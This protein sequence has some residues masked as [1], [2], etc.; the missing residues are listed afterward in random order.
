MKRDNEYILDIILILLA[1]LTLILSNILWLDIKTA[2]IPSQDEIVETE[3]DSTKLFK[4][5]LKPR[6]VIATYNGN[7]HFVLEFDE[8]YQ[9]YQKDIYA[10]FSNLNPNDGTEISMEEYLSLQNAPSLV[11]FYPQ[12][13]DLST[14]ISLIDKPDNAEAPISITEIYF[15]RDFIV[16]GNSQKHFKFSKKMNIDDTLSSLASENLPTAQNFKEL[17]NVN[18]NLYMPT[19]NTYKFKKIF[20]SND[21]QTL[22]ND[23]SY[24]DNLASRFL[25]ANVDHIKDIVQE[26]SRNLIYNNEYLNLYYSG[27]I[28]YENFDKINSKTRNLYTSFKSALSFIS[29]KVGNLDL[30]LSEITPIGDEESQGYSFKFNISEDSLPV[31]VNNPNYPYY[32]EIEVFNTQV[33]HFTQNYKKVIQDSAPTYEK[34]NGITLDKIIT[35]SK[36]IF[37]E[38]FENAIQ[39]I[40]DIGVTYLDN[41]ANGQKELRRVLYVQYK[42]RNLFFSLDSGRLLLER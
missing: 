42:N 11:F 38:P 8:I 22:I 12:T 20:Y 21:L 5:L 32:I 36:S 4:E 9:K 31:I 35:S 26:N 13:M 7:H 14:L 1:S 15:S 29:N 24:V 28:E 41:T 25:N 2:K 34:I 37:N 16:V 27:I 40:T 39:N 17:Y 30:Y 33:T 3:Y 23:E 18:K 10:V 19:Q 6:K